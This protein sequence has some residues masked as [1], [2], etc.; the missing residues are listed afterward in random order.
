MHPILMLLYAAGVTLFGAALAFALV[1]WVIDRVAALS[2]TTID[3][4]G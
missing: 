4:R 1:R 3:I 2:A